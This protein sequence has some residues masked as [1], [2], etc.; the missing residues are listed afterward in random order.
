MREQQSSH[1]G[2]DNPA[3]DSIEWF[4]NES[5]SRRSVLRKVGVGAATAVVATIGVGSYRVFDNG[6]LD[7]GDGAADDAWSNW[8]RSGVLIA[9]AIKGGPS[10]PML[11][12]LASAA[13]LPFVA[14][15]WWTIVAPMFTIVALVIGLAATGV[16][17]RSNG[18]AS[19]TISTDSRVA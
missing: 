6:I 1:P 12:I 16:V 11:V 5:M 7:R 14:L 13:T 15:T 8:H 10:R 19:A 18:A 9:A 3:N 17:R 4:N 2:L